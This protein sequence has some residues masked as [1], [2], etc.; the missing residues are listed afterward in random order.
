VNA[1]TF[2]SGSA[3][4]VVTLNPLLGASKN[5]QVGQVRTNDALVFDSYSFDDLPSSRTQDTGNDG[6][7]TLRA[8]EFGDGIN[9]VKLTRIDAPFIAV[10]FEPRRCVTTFTEV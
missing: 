10:T 8:M 4:T 6:P 7:V 3:T 2:D 1:A 9:G 5:Y